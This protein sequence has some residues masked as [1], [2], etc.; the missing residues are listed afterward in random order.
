[1]QLNPSVSEIHISR[2]VQAHMKFMCLRKL[3]CFLHETGRRMKSITTAT[4]STE[5][6]LSGSRGI[7]AFWS[8]NDKCM[9]VYDLEE[10]EEIS[11]DNESSDL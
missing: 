1:M 10:D 2:E 3:I 11:E 6:V 7:A 8:S 4:S 5:M 9:D